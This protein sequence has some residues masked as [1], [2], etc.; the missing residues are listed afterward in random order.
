[1]KDFNQFLSEMPRAVQQAKRLGLQGDGHGGWHNRKTG[2]FVAKTENGQ[3]TFY[4]KRQ[5][6]GRQD[7]AQTEREKRLSTTSYEET[8]LREKYLNGDI[9]N[10][11]D[12]VKNINTEQVGKII[13][14]GTNYLICVTEGGEMFKSWIKDVEEISLWG[15][16][17]INKYRNSK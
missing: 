14:R 8:D 3:L 15:I 17:F 12:F 9:F 10:D 5:R 2:E 7:P 13:R 16:Q 11:G 4:N 6:V 1:M